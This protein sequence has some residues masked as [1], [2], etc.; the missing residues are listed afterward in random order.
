MQI[1]DTAG[2]E[3]YRSITQTF[4]KNALGVLIVFDL[5]NKQSFNELKN[6]MH[7]IKSHAGDE[8]CKLLVG[9]KCD[10]ID[11]RQVTQKEIEDFLDEFPMDYIESSAKDGTNILDAFILMTKEIIQKFYKEMQRSDL[12]SG[13]K[14]VASKISIKSKSFLNR[15]DD[16]SISRKCC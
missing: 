15:E 8:V 16:N 2:Q 4:Y 11:S 3:R 1:W 6:W 7:H 9:N 14:N 12:I 5:S 13:D 10:K